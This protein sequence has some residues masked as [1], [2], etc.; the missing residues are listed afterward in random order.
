MGHPTLSAP[1]H[2]PKSRTREGCLARW[3]VSDPPVPT[4]SADDDRIDWLRCA[5]FFL[6]HAACLGVF[7]V[8]ASAFAVGIAIGL[9]VVR[10]FFITAFY[11]RYFSHRSFRTS[12]WVQL[13]GAVGA[14]TAAQRGPLWWA[15]HHRHHHAHSDGPSDKHSPRH[16]GMI[17]SHIGWFMTRGNF[18]T[19]HRY[20]RDWARFAELRFL[21][22]FDWV[23]FVVLGAVLF[24]VGELLEARRPHWNTNGAQL[25]VW[26]LISTVA[27]Y[28]VTYTINSLAH[29]FGSRR[30]ETRDD[31]RNNA[32]LALLTLGEGWHNNHHHYPASARQGFYWWEIDLTFYVLRFFA[33]L[34]MIW[35]LRPVPEHVRAAGRPGKAA[36]ALE[37]AR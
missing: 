22:R 17:F 20:V 37:E 30:F 21:N 13:L 7:W 6:V 3:L 23:P 32:M 10:M 19:D 26:Y 11:H 24:A 8:G 25:L 1:N 5:P 15:A 28:H 34:G 35:G 36:P 14:C 18:S 2:A 33:A 12:R 29:R 4:P 31:S 16:R 9:Y 27:L